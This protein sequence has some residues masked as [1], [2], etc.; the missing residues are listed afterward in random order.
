MAYVC[1]RMVIWYYQSLWHLC[2]SRWLYDITG[3]YDICVFQGGYTILPEPMTNNYV[4]HGG[5]MILQCLWHLWVSWWLYDIAGAYDIS[6]FHGGYMILP[7]PMTFVCFMVVIWY[8]RSL[9]HLCVSGWLYDITGAYDI[10]FVVNGGL[11]IIGACFVLYASRY[12]QM[13]HTEKQPHYIYH[14]ASDHVV[15]TPRRV[16]IWQ[17]THSLAIWIALSKSVLST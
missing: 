12:R 14:L 10:F 17:S 4:F 11:Q 1:F 6:V 9:C 7:E 16:Q 8:Y 15:E 3:A 2:V 13:N 5:Y